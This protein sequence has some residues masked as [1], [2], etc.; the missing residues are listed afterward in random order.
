MISPE[1]NNSL[2][3]FLFFKVKLYDFRTVSRPDTKPNPCLVEAMYL[4]VKYI[5]FSCENGKS[6]KP[7]VKF[8]FGL[9][10]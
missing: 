2:K 9:G 3:K 8:V 1:V 5:L 4:Y 6:K 7:S 10:N